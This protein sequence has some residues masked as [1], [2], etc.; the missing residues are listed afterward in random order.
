MCSHEFPTHKLEEKP[1]ED[2]EGT[3][4]LPVGEREEYLNNPREADLEECF[5]EVIKDQTT[6]MICC[7]VEHGDTG[8]E[9]EG[10]RGCNC[11]FC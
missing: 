8:S 5:G 4:K 10:T 3:Q 9:R 1:V 2:Q 6:D 7:R 11:R